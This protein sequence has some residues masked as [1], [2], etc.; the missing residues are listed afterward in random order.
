MRLV[1]KRPGEERVGRVEDHIV[2]QQ[3]AELLLI[4]SQEV[5]DALG[6]YRVVRLH[7]DRLR[8]AGRDRRRSGRSHGLRRGV[9]APVR[10]QRCRADRQDRDDDSRYCATLDR[11]AWRRC[12]FA[13]GFDEV[14]RDLQI[15]DERGEFPERLRLHGL[16]G[17]VL[18]LGGVELTL[19]VPGVEERTGLR[20]VAVTC[21]LSGGDSLWHAVIIGT[22]S[23]CRVS[24]STGSSGLS[25]GAA[26]GAD[27]TV[28]AHRQEAAR[29]CSSFPR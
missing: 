21:A 15:R 5:T 19:A 11:S 24:A 17:A 4:P 1:R 13:C 9:A 25:V 10:V 28:E 14:G 7:H 6:G 8:F 27:L 12:G 20:T 16:C 2:H 3:I 18:V 23:E 22:R 29:T 26:D